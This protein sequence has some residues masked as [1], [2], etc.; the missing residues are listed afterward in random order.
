M[1]FKKIMLITLL[2]LAVLTIG[3]ASASEDVDSLAVDDAGDEQVVE[4]PVDEDVVEAD[5]SDVAL[6]LT[7][8]DF[9]AN[10]TEEV[11]D[12]E[13]EDAV[14][15]TFYCP[16]DVNPNDQIQVRYGEGDVDYQNFWG[17][18]FTPKAVNNITWGSLYLQNEGT[19]NITVSYINQTENTIV[20]ATGTLK[21][22]KTYTANDFIEV[23]STTITRLTDYVCILSDDDGLNGNVTIYADDELVYNK[24]L[25]TTTYDG[26]CITPQN[27]TSNLTGAISIRVVYSRNDGKNYSKGA[28]IT[29]NLPKELTPKDFNVTILNTEVDISDFDKVLISFD[30][31]EGVNRYDYVGLDIKDSY[32]HI[33][34]QTGETHKNITLGDVSIDDSG[35]YNYT[36]YF[37]KYGDDSKLALANGTFK[38]TQIFTAEDIISLHTWD[39]TDRE[40]H[41]VDIY[42]N[43]TGIGLNGEINVYANGKLVYSK[44][45]SGTDGGRPIAAKELSG[46]FDGEFTIEVEYK[47]ADGKTFT[48]S[49]KIKFVDIVGAPISA[50]ISASSMTVTY[51]QN[52][53]LVATLKDANGK[54]ISGVDVYISVM[55]VKYPVKTNSKGQVEL[56]AGTLNP[57]KNTVK[58]TVENAAYKVSAKSVTVTVKKATPKLTA[59]KKT[60]KKSVKTKKYT[61]TLKNNV[62]KAIKSVKVKLTVNKKTYTAKTNAKGQATFKIT[63]LKKKGNYAATVKFA[64]NSYYNAKTVKPKIIVK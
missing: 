63:N 34:T 32:E 25:F 21:V 36:L 59:A 37:Y 14:V 15:V 54:A 4:A 53:K 44:K 20:L 17:E 55:G 16:E 3:V 26:V 6:E 12:V 2:L 51:N 48:V 64:G 11:I 50:T 13:D 5:E 31:P 1:K 43:E 35:V 62:N 57:G 22:T 18:D 10:I 61:V 23:Y 41:F 7:P 19:Y 29:F 52:K 38:V 9:N 28:T 45:Y 27:L 58:F 33:I 39:V 42:D 24:Y 40:E 8:E 30:W 56:A 49:E 47:R 46:Y 60:F